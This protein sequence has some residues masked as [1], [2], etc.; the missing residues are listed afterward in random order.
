MPDS[1][2]PALT[3]SA[4]FTDAE[5]AL[6]RVAAI[7]DASVSRVCTQ[8][9]A[10]AEERD[11]PSGLEGQPACYPYVAIEVASEDLRRGGRYAYGQV[12][13]QGVS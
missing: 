2:S 3:Q 6:A 7:Y 4:K 11:L 5:E 9:K 12:P 10:L 1:P 8:V 13:A